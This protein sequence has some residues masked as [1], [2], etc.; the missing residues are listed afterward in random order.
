MST[1]V[2]DNFDWKQVLIKQG[3]YH[4]WG[5]ITS[6]SAQEASEFILSM[7]I[8]PTKQVKHV[9]L[10]IN[11]EGGSLTDA[12]ALIDVMQHSKLPVHTLA[13]GQ[14][15]SAGL[16]VFM[17]G[18]RG[19]RLIT[20]NTMIMSHQWSGSVQ[21]KAHELLSAHQ[22]MQITTARVLAHYCKYTQ[23]SEQTILT[24]LLPPHDVYLTASQA[25]ELGIADRI[26][27]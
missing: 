16:M 20:P 4:L 6:E 11:S 12:F 2:E 15:S 17:A 8:K 3:I 18:S 13:L 22:D 14:V 26:Q 24:Q 10:I 5:E 21:G 27:S 23:Q 1:H 9:T 25:V 19:H 7:N